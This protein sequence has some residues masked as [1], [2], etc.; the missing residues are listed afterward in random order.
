MTPERQEFRISKPPIQ[1]AAETVELIVTAALVY[2]MLRPDEAAKH[3]AF[4]KAMRDSAG[5]W[6]SMQHTIQA[7]RNLP[8]T[9]TDV[10]RNK[11]D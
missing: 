5:D 11:E 6:I 10:T 2:Y 1:V 3:I 8:E 9:E 4:F 7:I